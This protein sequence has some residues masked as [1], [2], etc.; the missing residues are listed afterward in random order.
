MFGLSIDQD[1]QLNLL[2]LDHRAPLQCVLEFCQMLLRP[3][4]IVT[5]VTYTFKAGDS[6]EYLRQAW[7]VLVVFLV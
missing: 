5:V 6:G 4:L 7:A 1:V 3:C 2:V